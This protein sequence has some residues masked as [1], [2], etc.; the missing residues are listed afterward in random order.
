[1]IKITFQFPQSVGFRYVAYFVGDEGVRCDKL[2]CVP[3][4]PVIIIHNRHVPVINC[5]EYLQ[6]ILCFS[7]KR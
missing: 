7:Q 4:S 6:V 2:V 1:M 5:E 3:F